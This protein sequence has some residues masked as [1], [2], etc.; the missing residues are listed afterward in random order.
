MPSEC[1]CDWPYP[2]GSFGDLLSSCHYTNKDFCE[3]KDVHSLLE[4]LYSTYSCDKKLSILDVQLE[5]L[6]MDITDALAM[7]VH[8]FQ[9]EKTV[10]MST[11]FDPSLIRVVQYAL[12]LLS[13]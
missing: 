13:N 9:T 2:Q 6:H 11:I 1:G 5:C 8:L 12:R 7:L 10:W 3:Y 4:F